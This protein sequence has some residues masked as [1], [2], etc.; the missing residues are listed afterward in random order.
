MYYPAPHCVH[1]HC[2]VSINIQQVSMNVSG[3]SFFLHR[4]IQFCTFPLYALLCQVP[5]C[6]IAP[7][8]PTV[9]WQWNV[10]D[11]WFSLYC[12]TTN[13]YHVGHHGRHNKI[14]GISF[15]AIP[16]Y[17]PANSTS[18][19]QEI[20]FSIRALWIKIF[21]VKLRSYYFLHEKTMWYHLLLSLNSLGRAPF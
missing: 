3:C 16:A 14:G 20:I 13:M 19:C 1:I 21:W 6:Q 15:E 4:G 2:L 10:M 11:F 7:L 5:F 8:L 18:F 9:T 12:H 17:V